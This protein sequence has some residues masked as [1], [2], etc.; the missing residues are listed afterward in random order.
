M[1]VITIRLP[2]GELLSCS[3]DQSIIIWENLGEI[4]MEKT[5]FGGNG[6]MIPGGYG[7]KFNGKSVVSSGFQGAIQIWTNNE[8]TQLR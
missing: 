8:V 6:G 3:S 2:S 5:I 4:W 1:F 7:A